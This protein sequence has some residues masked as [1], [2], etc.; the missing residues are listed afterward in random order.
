MRLRSIIKVMLLPHLA[1]RERARLID[2]ANATDGKLVDAQN[3]IKELTEVRVS[4]QDELA[5]VR[6]E[7]DR[8]RD[9]LKALDTAHFVAPGHFYSPAP[10]RADVE[11]QLARQVQRNLLLSF[12]AIDLNIPEQL[13]LLD[14]LT[15]YYPQVPFKA[16]PVPGCS[17]NLRTHISPIRTASSCFAC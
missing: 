9:I 3:Y 2:R 4:L 5:E 16:D 13:N 1:L 7:R 12:P 14:S 6:D 15:S 11:E 17:T 8:F 10:S